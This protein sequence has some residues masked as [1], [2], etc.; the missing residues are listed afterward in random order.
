MARRDGAGAPRLGRNFRKSRPGAAPGIE[1]REL[2][3]P[4]ALAG[5]TRIT[6]IDY[7]VDEVEQREVQNLAAFIHDHRPAWAK[8]RWI[9][10]DGLGDLGVVRA[11]AE[12]Y[13]LHPLAVE[14]VL[15]V[16]QRPKVQAYDETAEYQARLCVIMRMVALQEG[17]LQAEQVSLFV[18]HHTVITFQEARGD[19][20]DRSGSGCRRRRPGCARARTPA[21]SPTR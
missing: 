19:V 15:H 20:W 16:P 7:S 1:P 9:N 17:E 3:P 6:C 13:Q 11:I 2:P 5:A 14:D 4:P 21:S 18:G 12:K 8:V 10:V